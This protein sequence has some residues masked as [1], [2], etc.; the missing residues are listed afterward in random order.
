MTLMVPLESVL[1]DFCFGGTSLLPPHWGP[2]N[3][4][5]ADQGWACRH[6]PCEAHGGLPRS[7]TCCLCAATGRASASPREGP[8]PPEPPALGSR[9]E[10][11]K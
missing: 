4:I 3:P 10:L 6:V 9:G 1:T 7:T 5:R 2:C 11:Q 8:F